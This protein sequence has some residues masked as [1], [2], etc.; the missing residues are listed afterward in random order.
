MKEPYT[1][2]Q[3]VCHDTLRD[4]TTASSGHTAGRTLALPRFEAGP[5]LPAY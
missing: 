5:R 4:I 1:T 3:L 2:P